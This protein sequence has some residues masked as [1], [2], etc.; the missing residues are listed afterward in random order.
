M[1][2]IHGCYD[3]FMCMLKKIVFS[4]DDNLI[5]AG[6]YI[7][8]GR[9]SYEMLRWI[10]R[11]PDNVKLLM[12]N[13]DKEFVDNVQLM[14]MIIKNNGLNADINS[15]E[16]TEAIYELTAQL[17][18]REDGTSFFDYYGTMRRFI[19]EK[20]VTLAD[21]MRWE[22][23]IA[24]FPYYYRTHIAGRDCVVVHAGYIESLDGVETEDYFAS[25]EDFYIYARDDA[26]IYGGIP[27]G[28]II[29]GHTPTTAEQELPFNDG[30]VYRS[31]DKE[32]DCIFYDIDCGCAFRQ[33]HPNAK[34][35]CIRLEDED[36]FYV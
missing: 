29:A 26:Y 4:D 5:I 31:Y 36:V 13:H 14:K 30:N 7:D 1:S 11:K 27:H 10:E 8:R 34:L 33:I 28:M 17:A 35:A 23:I 22:A 24:D 21:F 32:M 3:E 9:K 19:E 25:V 12:G 6:D 15:V 16:Q 20:K 2:D 18:M